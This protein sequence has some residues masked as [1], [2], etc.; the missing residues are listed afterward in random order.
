M[1]SKPLSSWMKKVIDKMTADLYTGKVYG[2]RGWEIGTINSFKTKQGKKP[3]VE[4]RVCNKKQ[5]TAVFR[6]VI[7]FYKGSGRWPE[8]DVHH[9]DEN[10]INDA[11]SNL[12]EATSEQN[13]LYSKRS[14]LPYLVTKFKRDGKFGLR[15]RYNGL[16]INLGSNFKDEQ[17]A[18]NAYNQFLSDREKGLPMPDY[19]RKKSKL[20]NGITASRGIYMARIRSQKRVY[21]V[22]RFRTIDEA[23]EAR[24]LRM[25]ELDIK[26]WRLAA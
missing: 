14:N 3:R 21:F 18:L 17:S 1:A 13:I 19:G 15:F 6:S 25:I 16:R 9:K 20:P 10:P 24:R 12:E 4:I 11:Y 22:G 26:E 8:Y 2:V 7:V 23:V 5:R